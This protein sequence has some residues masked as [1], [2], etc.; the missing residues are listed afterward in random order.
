[1]ISA[2]SKYVKTYTGRKVL[3]CSEESEQAALISWARF[4][5]VLYPDL[6]FLYHVPNGGARDKREGANLKRS[7]VLAGIPDLVLPVARHGYH[8]MYIEMKVEPNKPTKSQMEVMRRLKKNGSFVI[9]CYGAE[10]ARKVLNWYLGMSVWGSIKERKMK[11]ITIYCDRCGKEIKGYPMKLDCEYIDRV[12]GSAVQ[13]EMPKA[14]KDLMC[15]EFERDYCEGC[16]EEILGFARINVDAKTFF[17]DSSGTD[18][19]AEKMCE[20]AGISS[21]P[22]EAKEPETGQLEE[23]PQQ[24]PKEKLKRGRPPKSSVPARAGYL[25]GKQRIAIE[26]MYARGMDPAEVSRKLGIPEKVVIKA[27]T[28][29]EKLG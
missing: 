18:D 7:G 6:A 22:G 5:A 21:G 10:E 23:A 19:G 26:Q 14:I 29:L 4:N 11:K 16:M 8:H 1:M 25:T 20:D 9:T 17:E 3:R 27:I 28:S 15:D 13:H 2:K 12:D 24:E